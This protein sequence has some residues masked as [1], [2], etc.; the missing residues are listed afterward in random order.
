MGSE[1]WPT[2]GDNHQCKRTCTDAS[3]TV[4]KTDSKP[5]AKRKE[6]RRLFRLQGGHDPDVETRSERRV[7]YLGHVSW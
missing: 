3:Q 5:I 6:G 1:R 7:G 4:T 2:L